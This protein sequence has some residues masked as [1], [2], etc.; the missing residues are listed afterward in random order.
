MLD[1]NGLMGKNA[2]G[3]GPALFLLVVGALAAFVAYRR[4]PVSTAQP[5]LQGEGRQRP[6]RAAAPC[7]PD[8]G[9]PRCASAS[10]IPSLTCTEA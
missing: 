4:R 10:S 8:Q 6:V 3:V 2:M 5:L 7:P 1:T 9:A